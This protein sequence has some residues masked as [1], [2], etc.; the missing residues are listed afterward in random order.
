MVTVSGQIDFVSA[1]VLDAALKAL[2][3]DKPVVLDLVGL[4]CMDSSGAELLLAHERRINQAGGAMLVRCPS[5][6]ETEMRRS[7]RG[8]HPHRNPT[9]VAIDRARAP[10][11]L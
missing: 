8:R 7:H 9:A 2:N 11:V 1:P 3:S 10:S 5:A 6:L 4:T